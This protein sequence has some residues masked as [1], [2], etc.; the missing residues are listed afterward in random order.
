MA[1]LTSMTPQEI[2]RATPILTDIMVRQSETQVIRRLGR[3]GKDSSQDGSSGNGYSKRAAISKSHAL[4]FY[5]LA[6]LRLY[7]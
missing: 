2:R 3:L 6:I 5:P 4:L 1:V 7:L